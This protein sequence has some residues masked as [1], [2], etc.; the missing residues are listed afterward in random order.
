VHKF[1][2][3]LNGLWQDPVGQGLDLIN[4]IFYFFETG[5]LY[6]LPGWPSTHYVGQA[7]FELSIIL[8]QPPKVLEL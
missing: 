5:S 7:G 1:L 3:A 8:S 6:V 4:F 2:P